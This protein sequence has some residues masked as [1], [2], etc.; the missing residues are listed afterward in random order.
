MAMKAK[1]KTPCAKCGGMYKK[2]GA[3]TKKPMKKYQG[4]MGSSTVKSVDPNV[5][6]MAANA[7]ANTATNTNAAAANAAMVNT[8]PAPMSREAFKNAKLAVR[9]KKKLDKITARGSAD[10]A[11]NNSQKLQN[12]GTALGLI[13]TGLGAFTGVKQLFQKQ[14]KTGGSTQYKRGGKTTN[15]PVFASPKSA[16][17]SASKKAAVFKKGGNVKKK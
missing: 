8:P 3:T 1:P 7:A 10:Q 11:Q 4:D 6:A 9:Q 16:P 17:K 5:A 12:W 14:E 13:G 15:K 2:G